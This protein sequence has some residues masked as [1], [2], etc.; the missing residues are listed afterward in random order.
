YG[1]SSSE[2]LGGGDGGERRT[3][4]WLV[5]RPQRVCV[6]TGEC[7]L[8][9]SQLRRSGRVR[10]LRGLRSLPRARRFRSVSIPPTGG[11]GA[12]RKPGRPRGARARDSPVHLLPV[13]VVL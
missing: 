10:S 13:R 5:P 3:T 8:S 7:P 9:S 1:R 11:P 2:S 4:P 6:S 12:G